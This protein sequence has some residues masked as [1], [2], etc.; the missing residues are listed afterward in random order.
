M[1]E[2]KK[3]SSKKPVCLREKKKNGVRGFVS[4]VLLVQRRGINS[5]A[6]SSRAET[7]RKKRKGRVKGEDYFH[8]S[9]VQPEVA[10]SM[11]CY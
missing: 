6:S 9:S 3:R 1:R 10:D 11:Q 4:W 2:H 7:M 8:D 5:E